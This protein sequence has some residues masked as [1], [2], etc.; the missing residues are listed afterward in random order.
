MEH[1]TYEQYKAEIES[2]DWGNIKNDAITEARHSEAT[3]NAE[4]T[5]DGDLIGFSFLGTVF[6]L[7]PSG[8]YYTFW[9]TNQT[10]EDETEDE[11]FYQALNDVAEANGMYIENG[12]GDPCDIFASI[13]IENKIE[14]A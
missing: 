3:D 1:K 10:E 9:T 13:T 6:A 7:A 11:K 12:E 2:W 14:E 4:R 5:D 8:K